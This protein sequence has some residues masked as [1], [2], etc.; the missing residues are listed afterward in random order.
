VYFAGI[1]GGELIVDPGAVFIGLVDAAPGDG[2]ILALGGSGPATLEGFGTE[3]TGFDTLAFLPGVG[4]TVAGEEAG[5]AAASLISGFSEHDTLDITDLAFVAPQTLTLDGTDVLTISQGGVTLDLTFSSADTGWDFTVA[6]D[7]AGGVLVSSDIPCF[8]RGTRILTTRGKMA[9]EDI[10]MGDR[11]VLARAGLV[12]ARPVVWVGHRKVDIKRH[13]NPEAVWPV[14]FRAGAFGPGLPECD[15]RLS[16]KHAV[17]AGG[18]L[19]P[20]E[21][22]VNGATVLQVPCDTVEYWHVE[23]DQHDIVLAEGLAVESYLD[24]GNRTAFENGGAF[25]QL[26]PDFAAKHWLD[27]C[28]PL[29]LEGDALRLPRA[30]LRERALALGYITTTDPDVHVMADGQRIEAARRLHHRL[31]FVLPE[32]CREITLCSKSFK[33]TACHPE[34]PDVRRLG[35]CV[36][37]LRL[38]GANAP[39]QA[40]GFGKGWHAFEHDAAAGRRWTSGR[41][42]LPEGV[43][44]IVLDFSEGGEYWVEPKPGGLALAG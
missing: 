26:H 41:A 11:V 44:G 30:V 9:V 42:V 24:N 3:F 25:L 21:L 5:F 13:P 28:V 15:V 43:R 19:V 1:G 35:I 38:D 22:L 37:G 17:Y 4:W 39:L 34:S 36:H 16:P 2:D 33:P 7:G 18:V 8:A 10:A 23:L 40:N 31:M 27:T 32:A 20:A 29:V 6:S 12:A 14:L